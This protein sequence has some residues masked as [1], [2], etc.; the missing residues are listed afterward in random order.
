MRTD[1]WNRKDEAARAESNSLT[2]GPAASCQR[3]G[4]AAAYRKV[5][6]MERKGERLR[7]GELAWESLRIITYK[8]R[9]NCQAGDYHV[10]I[11]LVART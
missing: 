4:E 6:Q 10:E 9:L 3:E 11:L 7:V 8:N 5:D 1:E 2:L